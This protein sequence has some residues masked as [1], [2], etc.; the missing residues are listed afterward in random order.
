MCLYS[1][2]FLIGDWRLLLWATTDYFCGQVQTVFVGNYRHSDPLTFSAVLFGLKCYSSTLL[3][4]L[5]CNPLHLSKVSLALPSISSKQFQCLFDSGA[6]FSFQGR[7]SII[8]SS[9]ALLLQM[10]NG[11]MPLALCLQLVPQ[12]PQHLRSSEA[13]AICDGCPC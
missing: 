2:L 13:E 7:L 6:F 5:M 9:C 4:K 10:I 1:S 8:F 3:G 11:V 12:A